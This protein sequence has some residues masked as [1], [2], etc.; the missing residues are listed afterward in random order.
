MGRR[1][2]VLVLLRAGLWGSTLRFP[3]LSAP[4]DLAAALGSSRISP[5]GPETS[6]PPCRSC[7]ALL[8]PLS[9]SQGFAPRYAR[10]VKGGLLGDLTT[11]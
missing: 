9:A 11:S 4:P 10:S 1:A 7:D 8:L 3:F 6:K 2:V 5:T